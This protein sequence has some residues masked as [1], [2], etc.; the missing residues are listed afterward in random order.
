MC[1]FKK[2]KFHIFLSVYTTDEYIFYINNP[3]Y[4][5]KLVE[6]GKW[7]EPKIINSHI[8]LVL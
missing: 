7:E 1:M 4:L 6:C 3:N 8:L 2:F 5:I